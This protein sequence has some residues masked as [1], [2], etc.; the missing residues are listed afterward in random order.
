MIHKW[1]YIDTSKLCIVTSLIASLVLEFYDFA[2]LMNTNRLVVRMVYEK[3][4]NGVNGYHVW[5]DMVCIFQLG[6]AIFFVWKND[7]LV[8]GKIQL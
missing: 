7:C 6:T 8:Y 1:Q 5:Q 2:I 4:E 3:D